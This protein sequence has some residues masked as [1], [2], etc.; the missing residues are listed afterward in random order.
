[1]YNVECLMLLHVLVLLVSF[2][3][4]CY[5]MTGK[6]QAADEK[7]TLLI[8]VYSGLGFIESVQ[9][10]SRTYAHGYW[11]GSVCRMRSVVKSRKL[12]LH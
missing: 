1:M 2:L 7:K 4:V 8:Q 10:K 11:L 5:S 12:Q 6:Y 9:C 3:V